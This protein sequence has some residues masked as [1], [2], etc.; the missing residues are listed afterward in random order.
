[1]D[2]SQAEKRVNELREFIRRHDYL[3][4][5]KDAPEIS[6]REYDEAFRELQRLEEEFELIDP[7][8]PTQR[9]G[10][11][12]LSAF[13]KV[14]HL[15]PMLSLDS[16]LEQDEITRFYERV[17]KA[18]GYDPELVAEPKFDGLSVELIYESGRLS[19]GSTRGDGLVGEDVTENLK[20]IRAVPLLLRD[21]RQTPERVAFR[22][23]AIM[24]LQGFLDLNRALIEQGAEPFA[25]PRNAAA[26]SLRQLDMR[27]TAGRP[28]DLFVYDILSITGVSF[29]THTEEFEAMQEWGLRV[30]KHKR[31]C[32]SIDEALEFYH[33]MER[34][35]DRLPYEID[36]V[37][38]KVND[39]QGQ[40][41]LGYK[42][43]SPRW[44]I[45]YKFE[46]R[47]EETIIEDIVVS[48]GR[49]GTLTPVALLK[50][51]DVSGVT[52]SRATLHNADEVARKDVRAGDR[53][54]VARAGDVIPEVVERIDVPGQERGDPFTMPDQCPVCGGVVARKGA[55]HVCTAGLACRAQLE[56]SIIH[57]ASR[58][59]LDIE[60][61][62]EKTVKTLIAKGLV[63]ELADLYDLTADDLIPME[64]FAQK[65][66]DNLVRAIE[67][68]K[69]I[70]L[71]RFLYAIGIPGVG[72]H[73]AKV[74]ADHF[75][76]LESVRNATEEELRDVH[77]IGP[78]TSAAVTA[79]FRDQRNERE[80]DKLLQKGVRLVSAGPG[81]EASLLEGKTF[82]FTGSLPTLSRSDAQ[83]MVES[84]GARA[85]GSVSKS[86]DYVVAG[87]NPGSKLAKARE[88]GL[89][90]LDEDEFLRIT[91]Q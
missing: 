81:R 40:A 62:G 5:V 48:V 39:K 58:H 69:E 68:K 56:G 4:Y 60:G 71:E 51:V 67:E 37:V 66:A 22:A 46:P 2:R 88:L 10:G 72:S 34:E 63:K 87:E 45:A 33:Q 27:I 53:V 41:L 57:Y 28:L 43:R 86:T 9:V 11:R 84:L 54:R 35:R 52:I 21:S 85:T 59:A 29:A 90:I 7:D 20:T 14:E 3:Y 18:L 82:V 42:S 77:E 74:L 36:G 17:S 89:R 91:G 44:A 13:A 55:Y 8:S 26:G 25:N 31:L 19:R 49:T 75:Q 78:E 47:Q 50:P 38:L 6:D 30:D 12:P 32:A 64:G 76:T 16:I 70:P 65:S 80:I 83:K 61:L 79:F 1:M 23:E 24:P 73:V 15:S